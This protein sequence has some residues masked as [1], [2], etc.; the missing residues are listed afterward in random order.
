MQEYS[1][2]P[3]AVVPQDPQNTPLGET[4]TPA[5][6]AM[7]GELVSAVGPLAGGPPLAGV[8]LSTW[9]QR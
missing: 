9:E 3:Q 4:L 2:E 5:A 8:L 1:T 6:G 7:A